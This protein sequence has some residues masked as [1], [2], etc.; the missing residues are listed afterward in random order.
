M[1]ARHIDLFPLAHARLSRLPGVLSIVGPPGV[2]KTTWVRRALPDAVYVDLEHVTSPEDAITRLWA[3]MGEGAPSDLED[4]LRER[5]PEVLVLD[6]ADDALEA[7]SAGLLEHWGAL[8]PNM[9][10][11]LVTRRPFAP[12]EQHLLTLERPERDA[13]AALLADWLPDSPARL[14]SRLLDYTN[15]N[16]GALF[17]LS[18]RAR[19][20]P[21]DGLLED[22]RSEV[23]GAMG[24]ALARVADALDPTTHAMR[25]ALSALLGPFT[26]DEAR[27]VCGDAFD[28][29]ALQ[30]LSDAGWLDRP[31]PTTWHLAG[32]LRSD[33][34]PTPHALASR[35]RALDAWARGWLDGPR[36]GSPHDGIAL[37]HRLN[38]LIDAWRHHADSDST[39]HLPHLYALLSWLSSAPNS[40]TWSPS[41]TPQEPVEA[42]ERRAK[43]LATQGH[44]DAA[45]TTL[46]DAL[47]HPTPHS[48][49]DRAT[50]WA[51]LGKLLRAGGDHAGAG[52]A[53]AE[54]SQCTLGASDWPRSVRNLWRS[55]ASWRR[56]NHD[57]RAREAITELLDLLVEQPDLASARPAELDALA[58]RLGVPIPSTAPPPQ[59]PAPPE[60]HLPYDPDGARYQ[61]ADGAVV[62]LSRKRVAAR[63]LTTLVDQHAHHPGH[64][65]GFRALFDLGWP[66]QR[67]ITAASAMNRL[68]VAIARMRSGGLDGF[69]VT[70]EDGYMLAPDTT[71][72]ALD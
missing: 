21:L 34:A 72:V 41:A 13:C 7:G 65:L 46:Q 61:R 32:L 16:P 1:N 59:R 14:R 55:V 8:A 48:D 45:A 18:R 69:V 5:A 23:L 42:I 4:A 38:D 54:A 35:A 30:L 50:L 36:D 15:G 11:V 6:H 2:G 63:L 37:T 33:A 47:G 19:L 20:V 25:R 71:V 17:V 60:G 62:D 40:S 44:T 66:G 10:I 53:Y 68:R 67:H 51:R 31:T 57:E 43:R 27:A 56:A 49:V 24:F 64:A 52:R 39:L 58:R 12:W 3:A 70:A 9:R 26:L 29:D 28:F 22:P